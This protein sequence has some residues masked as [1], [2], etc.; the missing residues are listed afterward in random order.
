M[1]SRLGQQAG[2]RILLVRAG[3]LDAPAQMAGQRLLRI[4]DQAQLDLGRVGR[5][6][7][8]E[9]ARRA[10]LRGE[11][12]E[13]GDA[14]CLAPVQG[15]RVNRPGL[16]RRR[17]VRRQHRL[18]A[19]SE[20]GDA[21]PRVLAR[22]QHALGLAQQPGVARPPMQDLPRAMTR[23]IGNAGVAAGLVRLPAILPVEMRQQVH[24]RA[25]QEPVMH[26]EIERNAE[27][28]D[29]VT[30]VEVKPHHVMH[31][32]PRHT[33]RCEHADQRIGAL[34]RD[35][36]AAVARQGGRGDQGTALGRLQQQQVGP[37]AQ[38]LGQDFDVAVH[39][40]AESV[41]DEQDHRQAGAAIQF[42]GQGEAGRLGRPAQ[43]VALDHGRKLGPAHGERRLSG[44]T[45]LARAAAE[46]G[47]RLVMDIGVAGEHV[48]P[49]PRGGTQAEITLLAVAAAERLGIESAD[50][51]Q[52]RAL[53]IHAEADGGRHA[54]PP[55]R[56]GGPR[57]R[58]DHF[59]LQPERGRTAGNGR[60]AADRGVVR[61]G[62][63]RG[64][65]ILGI[66]VSGKAGEPSRRHLGI[67]VEQRDIGPPGLRH[68]AIDRGD[69]AQVAFVAQQRDA[70]GP[71]LPG[72]PGRERGLRRGIVDDDDPARRPLGVSQHGGDAAPRLGKSSVARDDDIHPHAGGTGWRASGRGQESRVVE[73]GFGGEAEPPADEHVEDERIRSRLRMPL[74]VEDGIETRMRVAQLSSADAQVMEQRVHARGRD[75]GVSLA[76]PGAVEER[77]RV[78]AFGQ[79]VERVVLQRI[80]AGVRQVGVFGEVE[81]GVEDREQL[82]GDGRD[83][84]LGRLAG[85]AHCP[86]DRFPS[87]CSKAVASMISAWPSTSWNSRSSC[88]GSR[89]SARIAS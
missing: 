19:P 45:G 17:L 85:R 69:E 28:A 68:G 30:Q 70:A 51:V 50:L 26:R 21:P 75:I 65:P 54:H 67:A 42:G 23:A 20:A 39:A 64:D 76:I 53:D 66:G 11:H 6:G 86:Q 41:G 72:K 43:D 13:H 47:F 18:L 37:P 10:L 78:A 80:K 83:G 33:G 15:G 52:C 38:A 87:V 58:V 88:A 60:I 25:N 71:R 31:M 12:A 73:R 48:P 84:R 59:G 36:R 22:A 55:A 82:G 56:V 7:Q 32:H 35:R 89:N 3:R 81:G 79:A 14:Q 4:S 5:L 61:P 57:R 9:H 8:S 62:R 49:A 16:G 29:H 1:R 74:R 77:V 24:L 63:D 2:Q 44:G 40:A 46:A 27:A 34:G